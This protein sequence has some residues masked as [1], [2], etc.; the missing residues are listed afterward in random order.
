M[1]GL[2][3]R[4]NVAIESVLYNVDQGQPISS[5]HDSA[6]QTKPFESANQM[7]ERLP[8]GRNGFQDSGM[9]LVVR[10]YF[11]AHFAHIGV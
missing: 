4:D 5:N 10:N 11:Y 7:K 6:L 2:V 9:A 1:L 8:T 3:S